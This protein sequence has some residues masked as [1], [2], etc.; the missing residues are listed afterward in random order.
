MDPLAFRLKNYAEVEPISG[1]PFSSKAL[2]E[3]YAQGA[4]RFGWSRRPLA[5]RQM[6]DEAGLLVGWGMGTATFPA[7]MFQAQARAILRND[8]T[9]RHGDRRARHGPGRLD[10]ARADRRRRPRARHRPGRVPLR[11]LRPARRR[12]RR[13]LGAYRDGRHGDP[14]RRRRRDRQARRSRHRA[15]SARRST[16][17]ATPAWSRATAG[18]SAAT[19]RAAARATPRS[20]PAPASREIEGQGKSASD[21][22]AQS[23]YAMH[24]HGAVFAEVK[25]DPELGQIR[26]T[27]LVGAFAAGRVINPRLVR[28]QYY[29]GMIW[30]VSFALHER[31]DHGPALGPADERRISASTMCR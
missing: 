21:P 1:K 14:R 22:A 2:R 17:P 23:N 12:H 31:A 3:C 15:T 7:L 25:V 18:C 5:P 16:A 6:R 28:S 20:S 10:R 8:G 11:R 24:A 19:T 4:E 30:G 13:R 29:G 9:R 26:A 27:R